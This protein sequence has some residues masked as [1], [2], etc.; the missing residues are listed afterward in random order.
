[1][2]SMMN[3]SMS[4]YPFPDLVIPLRSF[5]FLCDLC[6]NALRVKLGEA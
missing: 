1:M 2:T 4:A 6:V 3:F 5:F